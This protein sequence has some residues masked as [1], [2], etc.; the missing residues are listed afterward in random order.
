[1]TKRRMDHNQSSGF[2]SVAI[3]VVVVVICGYV[4]A[5]ALIRWLVVEAH[6]GNVFAAVAGG[7][8][9]ALSSLF[10][11]F[12]AAQLATLVNSYGW[13][14]DVPH[15]EL[16]RRQNHYP[17]N[18]HKDISFNPQTPYSPPEQFMS[19]DNNIFNE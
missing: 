14:R 13:R 7:V 12:G 5:A 8:L 10:L 4:T 9:L 6:N 15:N 19:V 18:A 2:S 11:G 1:M 16:P 17:N 3:V